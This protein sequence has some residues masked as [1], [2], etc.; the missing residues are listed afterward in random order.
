MGKHN[1]LPTSWADDMEI[2]DKKTFLTVFDEFRKMPRLKKC[3][4]DEIEKRLDQYFEICSSSGIVPTVE[5]LSL[6]LGVSRQ[7]MWKWQE[8]ECQAGI[9]VERAKSVI[10]ALM[11]SATLQGKINP[12]YSIWLQKNNFGYADKSEIKYEEHTDKKILTASELPKLNDSLSLSKAELLP[13]L[14]N[15]VSCNE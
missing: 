7:A 3:D 2:E 4:T 14:N 8:E 11:T 10:N 6:A 5:G 15:T 1:N 13:Q 9:I 12:I